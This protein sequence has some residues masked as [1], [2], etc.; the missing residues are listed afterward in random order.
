LAVSLH[1]PNQELRQQ[2]IPSAAHY[3]LEALI[4]DCRDYM[5]STGRRVSFE[6]TLIAGINDLPIHARQLAHLL[7][8]ASQS[9]ARLHVNL[10]PYNP[11]AEANY[12][13]P[14]P[15]RVAEFVRLLEEHH[16]QAS[17]RQTRGLDGN[18]ACGQ[19][20]GSFLRASPEPAPGR[21]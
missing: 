21:S 11:I 20:R 2:L 9:G 6:Y 17:V 14:H 7:R 16:V 15:A 4:Q 13:R 19:L 12:Q 10:I 5:L 3:P 8:Q 18:A 1:A